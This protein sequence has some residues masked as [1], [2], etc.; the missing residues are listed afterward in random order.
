MDI[1]LATRNHDKLREFR[2]LLQNM[3]VRVVCCEDFSGCP[4]VVEDGTTLAE[5]ALKK[6]RAVA[7]HTRRLTM[8]DDSGLEVDAL[9]GAPGIYSARYGGV[10][11]D[12]R[13]NIARLL[14]ELDGVPYNRRGAQFRCVIA[15]VAPDGRERI[16]EG[17]CRGVIIASPRGANGF[18]YD[19]VFLDEASGLTLAE[20][21]AAL[22]NCISHRGKAA[23]ELK[24]ILPAFLNLE[25]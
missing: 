13:S 4:D 20:M 2:E 17:I 15:L 11:G 5:N 10:Q 22:K 9:G 7:S 23:V 3:P 12:A 8:A 18:G 16:V 21:D 14:R 25:P 19:P 24:K 1:V 6:A